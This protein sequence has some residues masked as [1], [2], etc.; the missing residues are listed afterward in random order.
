[1]TPKAIDPQQQKKLWLIK[2][3]LG[4]SIFGFGVCL[5]SEAAMLKYGGAATWDWVVNG[6]LALM[7]LNAGLCVFGDAVKH[8]ALFESGRKK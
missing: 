1:M 5:V 8:R 3:P 2:A 4:L 7:V 6:T